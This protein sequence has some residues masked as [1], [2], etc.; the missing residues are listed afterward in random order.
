MGGDDL[1]EHVDTQVCMQAE[2]GET[3]VLSRACMH[4][5]V[6]ACVYACV[7]ACVRVPRACL[8]VADA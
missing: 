3:S 6:R 7:Y 8:P 4:A 5:C 1:S 2:G